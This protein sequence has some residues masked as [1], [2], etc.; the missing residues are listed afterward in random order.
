MATN[1]KKIFTNM[2]ISVGVFGLC[3]TGAQ[4]SF[5]ISLCLANLPVFVIEEGACVSIIF[6][7]IIE[8]VSRLISLQPGIETQY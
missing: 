6:R 7:Y 2:I 5:K 1:R 4:K 3:K 8:L